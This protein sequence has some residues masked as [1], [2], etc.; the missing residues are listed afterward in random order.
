MDKDTGPKPDDILPANDNQGPEDGPEHEAWKRVDRAA[1]RLA[2][3]IGR[4]MAREDFEAF[5]ANDNRPSAAD[6]AEDQV[7]KD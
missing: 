2:Q 3:L 1:I 7:D 5:I 6:G 4:R